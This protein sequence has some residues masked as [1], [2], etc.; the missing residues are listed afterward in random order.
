MSGHGWQPIATAPRDGAELLI[1]GKW[2]YCPT[3]HVAQWI[4]GRWMVDTEDGSLGVAISPTH[5][6][7]LPEAPVA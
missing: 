2:A 5:W 1:F 4:D 3:M 7:P 6:M